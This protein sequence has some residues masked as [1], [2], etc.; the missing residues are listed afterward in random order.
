MDPSLWSPSWSNFLVFLYFFHFLAKLNSSNHRNQSCVPLEEFFPSGCTHRRHHM[1]PPWPSFCLTGPCC[2]VET[3]SL[4]LPLTFHLLTQ[5]EN[6]PGEVTSLAY[7]CLVLDISQ[8]G[9][10]KC[11]YLFAYR[12]ACVCMMSR[13]RC[14][15]RRPTYLVCVWECK[16]T[17]PG[18]ERK[19]Q[20]VHFHRHV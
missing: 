12:C 3:H 9:M 19:L 2:S 6:T 11:L 17:E 14:K 15:D 13:C 5:K 8:L 10:N 18:K 7:S 4:S 1:I 16:R 20:G